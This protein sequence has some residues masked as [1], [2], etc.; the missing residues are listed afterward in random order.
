MSR[1]YL[2]AG[3]AILVLAAGYLILT[4]VPG[5]YDQFA[6]CVAAS[7]AK[8]YGSSSCPHCNDQKHMFGNSWRFMGYVECSLPDGQGQ[9]DACKRA[10][11]HSYPTWVF[12]D[13]NR[14]VGMMPLESIA[15]KTGCQLTQ[16]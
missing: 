13:G 3:L 4:N 1:T 5:R 2:M 14:S 8:M 7:G 15:E 16:G 10:G 11:I 12:G 6:K 9:A